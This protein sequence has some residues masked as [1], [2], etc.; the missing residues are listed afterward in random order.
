VWEAWQA[1][2]AHLGVLPQPLP[3]PFDLSVQRRVQRDATLRFEGRAY[4]VPF[5]F[6]ER[7]V[8]VRGC[9]RVVQV[10][11]EGA[12]V[13]EHPRHSRERIL[14]DPAHYDGPSTD[15]VAAPVPLG[16]MGRR[17]QEI[18]E[19]P[20]TQRPIDLYADLAEVAR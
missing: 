16:R 2:Q 18:W 7:V 14:L 11:A 20:P 13:A 12:V 8:E 1:E 19:L 3:E 17:L 6:A 5:R 15:D 9:A 10:W 4:S